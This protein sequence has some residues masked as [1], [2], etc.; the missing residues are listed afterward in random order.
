[1]AMWYGAASQRHVVAATLLLLSGTHEA[2]AD[3]TPADQSKGANVKSVPLPAS[4]KPSK[5]PPDK[6]LYTLFNPTPS[7]E[8]RPF[9]TDRPGKTHSAQTVDAGHFQYE[10]DIWNYTWDHWSPTNTS[11][12]AY[13]LV[14]PN[15]KLG[16]TNWAELDAFLPLYNVLEFKNQRGPGVAHAFGFGDVLL[17][18][19]VNFFGNDSGDQSFGA[20]AFVKVPTAGAGLGNNLVEYTL[21]LPFTTA[22]PDR[23]SLTLE[24]ALGLL[25]NAYKQGLQGDRQFLINMNRPVIGDN[26]I[27]ALE[28]ALDFSADHNIGP[29]HT[30][31]PSVQWLV[32]PN[33]QLDAGAYIGI[34]K[35]APDWNPYVGIS[36]RY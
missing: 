7:D 20:I 30:I 33:V 4:A 1:M 24:P 8:M 10:G 17:G 5:P 12:R 31:D 25:R 35:A 14:N 36:F 2:R 26:V 3:Q 13:T 16:I 11:V 29:R 6:S 15:L 23:F 22:L 27:V 19:K 21:N 18:G 34:S 9:S 28:L 32:T